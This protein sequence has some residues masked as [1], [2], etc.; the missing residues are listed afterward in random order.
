MRAVRCLELLQPGM[1]QCPASYDTKDDSGRMRGS[2]LSRVEIGPEIKGCWIRGLTNK[3]IIS[4]AINRT[5][6]VGL[7]GSFLP[8]YEVPSASNHSPSLP[9]LILI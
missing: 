8:T 1:L 9:L 3:S 4:A 6:L 7:D 2:A 5:I